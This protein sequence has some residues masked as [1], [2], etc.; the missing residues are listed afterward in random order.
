MMLKASPLFK[1]PTIT[2]KAFETF[3]NQPVIRFTAQM[4]LV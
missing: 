3:D 4:E 2:R 1:Q